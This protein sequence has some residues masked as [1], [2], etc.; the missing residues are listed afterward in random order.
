[1]LTSTNFQS[2]VLKLLKTLN[3][4]RQRIEERYKEELAAV[5]K[6]IEAV[7][8]TAKLMRG[9][10]VATIQKGVAA[11]AEAGTLLVPISH[12]IGK[13]PKQALMM[14]AKRNDGI[15]HVRSARQMLLDL[16]VVKPSKHL[17]GSIYTT[18]SRSREFEKG[19]M[20]GTFRLI[21]PEKQ[22]QGALLQ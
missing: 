10:A 11:R 6:E 20:P 12:L 9:D 13:K 15:L 14:I 1:M 8:T 3:E 21:N 18:L 16:G 19:A 17:W 22:A 5:D 4:K 7:N 2:D